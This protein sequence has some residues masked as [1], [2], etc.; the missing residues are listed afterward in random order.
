[1]AQIISTEG[2]L[3]FER[4]FKLPT[5]NPHIIYDILKPKE[6]QKSIFFIPTNKN[7]L[8]ILY[9]S[10]IRLFAVPIDKKRAWAKRQTKFYVLIKGE[11]PITQKATE[12][13]RL[14][15]NHYLEYDSANDRVRLW[16]NFVSQDDN[17]S[18][19]VDL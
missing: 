4:N 3:I 7:A 5:I 11:I 19:W 13:S 17:K 15:P 10:D 1:M 14:P 16:G 8:D 9:N 2:N 18:E 6:K 12:L